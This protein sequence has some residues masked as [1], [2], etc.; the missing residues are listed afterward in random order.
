MTREFARHGSHRE[1]LNI[2]KKEIGNQMP[3]TNEE[4]WKPVCEMCYSLALN[5]LEELKTSMPRRIADFIQTKGD[6][7]KY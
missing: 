7:K 2:M 1:R 5:V 3:C 6:A 4:M